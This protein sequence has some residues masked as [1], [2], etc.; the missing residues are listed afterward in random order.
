MFLL[1]SLYNTTINFQ[2]RDPSSSINLSPS[3]TPFLSLCV[4]SCCCRCTFLLLLVLFH[5]PRPASR[6]ARPDPSLAEQGA[7]PVA[8]RRPKR[9]LEQRKREREGGESSDWV[10]FWP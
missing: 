5:Q 4:L 2:P 6:W 8:S 1:L 9:G 3:N 10:W 7:R